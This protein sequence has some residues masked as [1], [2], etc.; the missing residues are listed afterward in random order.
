M[1]ALPVSVDKDG[2]PLADPAVSK[3]PKAEA[4]A[5]PKP[6][7]AEAEYIPKRPLRSKY[8]IQVCPHVTGTNK[9]R[10][11]DQPSD[12]D[13]SFHCY[14]DLN[15][16]QPV[17]LHQPGRVQVCLALIQNSMQQALLLS[18]EGMQST[19]A[20]WNKRQL[21]TPGLVFRVTPW[22]VKAC[23]AMFSVHPT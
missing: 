20:L 21:L 5:D 2:K 15:L 13:V 17:F 11:G 1:D 22:V 12:W 10:K 19:S 7:K 23:F 4:G 6:K 8:H 16:C 9:K 18:A 14:I 3:D